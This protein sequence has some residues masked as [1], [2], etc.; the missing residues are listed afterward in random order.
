MQSNH[1]KS[2]I[3]NTLFLLFFIS[4]IVLAVI[5]ASLVTKAFFAGVLWV[6]GG[7]FDMTWNDVLRISKMGLYGGGI[8]GVGIVLARYLKIRG[9]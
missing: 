7:E 9:F 1:R 2:W 6:M 8:L 3:L 4:A 5:I